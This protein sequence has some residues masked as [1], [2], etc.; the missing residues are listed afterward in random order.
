MAAKTKSW[1]DRLLLLL[2]NNIA[3][4]NIGDTAG[5]QPSSVAGNLYISLHFLTPG[6]TQTN[7]EI[8]YTGYARV[9]VVRSA[10]GWTLAVFPSGSV[11]NAAPITFPICSGVSG[12]ARAVGIGTEP[13]GPGVLLYAGDLVTPLN[14]TIGITPVFTAGN[15]IL[16]EL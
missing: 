4:A 7:W 3:A 16:T 6:V 1:T 9:P 11:N 2:F 14:V 5:L 13:T 8:V 12:W 15:L 10:A